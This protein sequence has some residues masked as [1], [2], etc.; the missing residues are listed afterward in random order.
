MPTIDGYSSNDYVS[1]LTE[2]SDTVLW[3][4][5]FVKNTG[6]DNNIDVR[7]SY[8]TIVQDGYHDI[9]IIL[10]PSQ[11]WEFTTTS[12]FITNSHL[13]AMEISIKSTIPEAHSDYTIKYKTIPD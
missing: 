7:C 11:I 8:M 12:D 6:P 4:A 3:A 5:G 9:D 10:S 13:K 1:A 2:N